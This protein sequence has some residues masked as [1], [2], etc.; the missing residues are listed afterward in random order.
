MMIDI[1]L[2]FA[3]IA[4][5]YLKQQRKNI[6]P[7]LNKDTSVESLVTKSDLF[8]SDLFEKVIEDNFLKLNHIIIDEEK[9]TGYGNKVFDKINSSEYQFVID[10]IDG[11]IQYASGHPLYGISI[12]VYKNAKPYMGLIYLPDLD[13]LTYFDG[14]KAYLVQNA[15]SQAEKRTEILPGVK[16]S[17]PIIF[18]HPWLWNLSSDFST[19]KALFIDYFSAVSQSFYTITGKAKAYCMNLK[20]WDIAGTIPITDYLG[21]KIYNYE[22]N[23]ICNQISE[24]FFDTNMST[25]GSYILCYPEDY[26]KIKSLVI[27]KKSDND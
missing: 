26:E 3:N 12:G 16:S 24:E 27:P 2:N 15:F 21:M 17:S 19:S 20:L 7:I 6:K 22:N 25:K 10:P 13:E 23:K 5:Q 4:G 18:G 11:T 14:V 9:T 8:V 1:L